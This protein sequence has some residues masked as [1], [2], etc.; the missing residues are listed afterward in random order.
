M[1]EAENAE[2]REANQASR[3]DIGRVNIVLDEVFSLETVPEEMYE[4]LS[5]VSDVLNS[6]RQRLR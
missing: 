4:K 6:L 5:L 2:L 1:L 3:S